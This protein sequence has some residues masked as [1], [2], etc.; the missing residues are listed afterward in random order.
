MQKDFASDRLE[1][2]ATD[3]KE[4]I[5]YTLMKANIHNY[6]FIEEDTFD[7]NMMDESFASSDVVEKQMSRQQG[8]WQG[9]PTIDCK[10]KHKDGS[11]SSVRY[12][13]QGPN[14]FAQVAHYTTETKNVKQYFDSFTIMP[15]IYPEVKLR[16]DTAMH[17]TV[18]SPL[19]PDAKKQK[20]MMETLR[21]LMDGYG[22]DDESSIPEF[23]VKLIGN[24]TIGEKVFVAW[25]KSPKN[26][27]VK[28]SSKIFSN[29][30]YSF[31]GTG[32]KDQTYLYLKKDS[33]IT[34]SGMRYLFQQV[35]DTNSSRTIISKA[36]YKSGN[37]FV[38]MALTDTLTPR[39]SL[40][41][42]FIQTFTPSDT[43]KGES[44]FVK[45][46][47]SFFKDFASKD[48]ATYAKAIKRLAKIEFDTADVPALK[49]II[50]TL[51]W[52]TKD[53]LQLK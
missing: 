8:K 38:M 42:N 45:R 33:G 39:S 4:N 18:R 46:N 31:S 36:F 40:L 25:A 50:D 21:N 30:D 22:D 29:S 49:N 20:D 37:Y 7:L 12:L 3:S 48:S 28:D 44:P 11:F 34:A 43:V 26:T 2:A 17:F 35:T 6:G 14:Y 51:S 41:Y 52:K 13:L 23:G 19:F 10:Y 32:N 5:T 47:A 24:D 1:Y 16:V 9:Y 15:F 53:Y 27:Y